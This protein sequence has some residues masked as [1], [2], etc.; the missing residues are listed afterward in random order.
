MK[1]LKSDIAKHAR[2]HN[3]DAVILLSSGSKLMGSYSNMS[4]SAQ[5][6]R[7][8]AVSTGTGVSMPLMRNDAKFAIVRYVKVEAI[9]VPVTP[10]AL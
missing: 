6:Y 9:K 4:A 3:A 5:L 7:N 10:S 1:G 2:Q 8:T